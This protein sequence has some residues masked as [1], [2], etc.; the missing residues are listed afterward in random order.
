VTRG[1]KVRGLAFL[2]VVGLVAGVV[3][4]AR[5]ERARVR[6]WAWRMRSGDGETRAKARLRLLEIGRPAIDSVFA[7]LVAGEVCDRASARPGAALR[8]V[9]F[10][11]QAE[12]RFGLSD[13]YSPEQGTRGEIWF[14][15]PP[16]ERDP[17]W[18]RLA[19][20]RAPGRKLLLLDDNDE[21]LEVAVP[22]EDPL[23]EAIIEETRARL[24]VK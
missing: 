18:E 16:K 24:P 2:V 7:E 9:R 4:A 3:V 8:L 14:V 1:A 22:K 20:P 19:Q 13:L 6:F 23:S 10:Q 11:S 17:A 12:G 15:D 21:I 5:T